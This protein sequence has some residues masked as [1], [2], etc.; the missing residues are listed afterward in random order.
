MKIL[1]LGNSDDYAEHIP[2]GSRAFEFA[3]RALVELSGE[4]VETVLRVV[5]PAPALPDMMTPDAPA[6]P[7]ATASFV[8]ERRDNEV[9]RCAKS[10]NDLSVI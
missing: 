5:W 6:A 8:N 9:V 10:V 2:V 7:M 3:E 1:R 4:P